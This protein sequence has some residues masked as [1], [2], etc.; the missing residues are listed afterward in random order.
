MLEDYNVKLVG[1]V[2]QEWLNDFAFLNNILHDLS[3][4]RS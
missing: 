2:L 4:R 1:G 3:L